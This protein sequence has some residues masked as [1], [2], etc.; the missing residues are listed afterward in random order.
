[1]RRCSVLGCRNPATI[2]Q[3]VVPPHLD[4][5]RA[6]REG[7]IRRYELCEEHNADY[8]GRGRF[9]SIEQSE[10]IRRDLLPAATGEKY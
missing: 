8:F 6:R 2:V 7:W 5:E 4:A 1:L 3:E 10:R 9:L